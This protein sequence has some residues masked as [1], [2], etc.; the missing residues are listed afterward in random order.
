MNVNGG[1]Q[2]FRQHGDFIQYR[3]T[4]SVGGVGAKANF[5]AVMITISIA[6]LQTSVNAGVRIASPCSFHVDNREIQQGTQPSAVT[7]FGRDLGEKVIV[8]QSCCAAL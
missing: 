1:I 3:F 8:Y 5:Y 4:D 7:L 6:Q 2:F